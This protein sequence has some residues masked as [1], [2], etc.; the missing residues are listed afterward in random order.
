MASA[1]SAKKQYKNLKLFEII[2][3]NYLN[4]VAGD[5]KAGKTLFVLILIAS[6]LIGKDLLSG[7]AVEKKKILLCSTEGYREQ[8]INVLTQKFCVT[9]DQL[10]NLVILDSKKFRNTADKNFHKLKSAISNQRPDLVVLDMYLKF[11]RPVSGYEKLYAEYDKLHELKE[12]Y[13]I[14]ILLTLHCRKAPAEKWHN[15]VLGSKAHTAA[16][17][18]YFYIE[19]DE[20]D[21]GRLC[22]RGRNI[23]DFELAYRLDRSSLLMHFFENLALSQ[24]EKNLFSAMVEAG[25]PLKVKE[26]DVEYR[27]Y[28]SHTNR[29]SKLGKMGLIQKAGSRWVPTDYG[30]D[31]HRN[32]NS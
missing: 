21:I 25:R 19:R 3:G 29:L 17:E 13:A 22:G 11:R 5:D 1:N 32:L 26:I 12:D 9:P 2:S 18:N 27:N 6:L 20:H 4:M 30:K 28:N 15:Q 23:N 10:D 14:G 31:F 16:M 8:L 24:L 7:A